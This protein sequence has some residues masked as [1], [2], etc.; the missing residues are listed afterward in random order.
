MS[1][2]RASLSPL[3]AFL[4]AACSATHPAAPAKPASPAAQQTTPQ[5]P[6]P[7]AD[8]VYLGTSTRFRAD[9]SNCPHPGLVTLIVQDQQFEYRWDRDVSIEAVINSDGSVHGESLGI[10]LTGQVDGQTMSGDV[11]N[12]TCALHFTVR[13]QV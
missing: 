7:T 1:I 6:P 9:R 4:L 8:G 10:T 2:P 12:T 5:L 11:T 13:R 3:A